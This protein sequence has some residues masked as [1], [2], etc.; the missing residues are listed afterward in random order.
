MLFKIPKLMWK[1][2]DEN[3]FSTDNTFIEYVITKV[4]DKFLCF[5]GNGRYKEFNELNEAKDWVEQTHYPAQVAKYL[6]KVNKTEFEDRLQE[7]LDAQTDD[8]I[9][10]ND[11][12]LLV[13]E[14]IFDFG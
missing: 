1:P 12:H 5:Y 3:K 14:F 9:N 8:S 10:E 4:E 2:E 11:F 6:L 7:I 13:N